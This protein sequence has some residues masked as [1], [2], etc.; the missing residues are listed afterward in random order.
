M[1]FNDIF[2][3]P[4]NETREQLTAEQEAHLIAEARR[5]VNQRRRPHF[6]QLLWQYIPALRGRAASE[7]RRMG[8]SVDIDEVRSNV[9]AGFTEAV[10]TNKAGVRLIQTLERSILRAADETNMQGAMTIPAQRR[11]EYRTAMTE[12]GGNLDSAIAQARGVLAEASMRALH[13]ALGGHSSIYEDTAHSSIAL[14][15]YDD[16]DCVLDVARA[17]AALTAGSDGKTGPLLI[18]NRAF[19]LNGDDSAADAV[20]AKELKRAALDNPDANGARWTPSR[21]TIQRVRETALALMH[22][23]LCAG[24]DPRCNRVH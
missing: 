24:H 18:I 4:D 15:P 11:R 20:I 13:S 22:D 12:A 10:F 16:I 19:G 9:L 7:Y 14:D 3:T 5:E 2:I 8:G 17:L 21:A 6:E 1:N 23:A